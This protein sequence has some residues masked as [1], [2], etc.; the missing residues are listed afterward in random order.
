MN[1]ERVFPFL[2][3]CTFHRESW[4]Q[5]IL[6]LVTKLSGWISS[7]FRPENIPRSSYRKQ[8]RITRKQIGE[9]AGKRCMSPFSFSFTKL[10]ERTSPIIWLRMRSNRQL[11]TR[12]TSQ[13]ETWIKLTHFWDLNSPGDVL[14][15]KAP[16]SSSDIERERERERAESSVKRQKRF[17]SQMKF[18]GV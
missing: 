10:K 4:L 17:R 15:L 2:I 16:L 14:R 3:S 9:K 5:L 18:E 13:S 6:S 11:T 7:F 8:L 1:R 12:K